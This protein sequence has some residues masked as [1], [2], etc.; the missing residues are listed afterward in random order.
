MV[1]RGWMGLG[2][3]FMVRVRM[4]DNSVG[5]EK[6]DD[7]E[8]EGFAIQLPSNWLSYATLLLVEAELAFWVVRSTVSV[9][10]DV[11][12]ISFLVLNGNGNT[13]RSDRGRRSICLDY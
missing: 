12:D 2:V 3:G 4:V 5:V 13:L 6:T 8:D 9:Q 11:G 7:D 1:V 10:R